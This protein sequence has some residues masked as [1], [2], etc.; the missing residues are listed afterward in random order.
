MKRDF[1]AWNGM[2]R[3][4]VETVFLVVLIYCVL[5]L[6]VKNQFTSVS[7]RNKLTVIYYMVCFTTCTVGFSLTG[8]AQTFS[9][10]SNS[11]QI[12]ITDPELG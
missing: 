12:E 6:M 2:E 3:I 9:G 8:H 7:L 4:Q 1:I 5:R 10:K 11:L